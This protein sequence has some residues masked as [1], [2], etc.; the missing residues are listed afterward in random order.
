MA[1]RSTIAIELADGTVKQVYCHWDG[2][3]S[4]NGRLLRDHYSD[5][6]QLRQLIDLG[7]ISSL[8]PTIGVQHPFSA[9]EAGMDLREYDRLYDKM[10]TFYARDRGETK[11]QAQSYWDFGMYKISGRSEE[12]DYILRNDGVWYYRSYGRDFVELGPDLQAEL[13]DN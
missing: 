13:V 8:A 9:A 1:T 4:F 7:D 6:T 3:L 12:F 10:T 11:C 5:P 2:Y